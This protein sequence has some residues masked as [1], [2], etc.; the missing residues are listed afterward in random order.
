[1]NKQQ[2]KIAGG[3]IFFGL[4]IGYGLLAD[5][6]GGGLWVL[7]L[8]IVLIA[9][10]GFVAYRYPATRPHIKGAL[11]F[12]KDSLG[13]FFSEEN[14]RRRKAKSERK[15][16][17][18]A[19]R[20][21]ALER[22][23]NRCQF[24]DVKKNQRCGYKQGLH[25]HHIDHDPSNSETLSNLICLCANHHYEIHRENKEFPVKEGHRR[26]IVSFSRGT[27]PRK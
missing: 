16:I 24:F 21:K 27:Y 23:K 3:I 4:L 18:T 13:A 22:A 19:L 6:L 14:R 12:I 17:P 20:N 11:V 8:L 9:V 2:Q 10:I 1:M 15:A 26:K 7:I 25:V 5:F